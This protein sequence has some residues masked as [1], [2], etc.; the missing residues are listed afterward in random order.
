MANLPRVFE[1]DM[2]LTDDICKMNRGFS[3]FSI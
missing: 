3:R 1:L 2:K